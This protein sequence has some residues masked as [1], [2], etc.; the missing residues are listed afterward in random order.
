MHSV[1]PLYDPI[2]IDDSGYVLSVLKTK[3]KSSDRIFSTFLNTKTALLHIQTKKPKII[4][5]TENK[6]KAKQ[7]TTSKPI[8]YNFNKVKLIQNKLNSIETLAMNQLVYLEYYT[9]HGMKS[10]F[11][12]QPF[13]CLTLLAMDVFGICVFSFENVEQNLFVLLKFIIHNDL[14]SLNATAKQSEGDHLENLRLFGRDFSL[15]LKGCFIFLGSSWSRFFFLV[16]P[17]IWLFY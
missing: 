3:T 11:N 15:F 9:F 2:K 12:F 8:I 13:S 7:E 17:M 4:H 5:F 10:W 1:Y 16:C 14:Y 6:I